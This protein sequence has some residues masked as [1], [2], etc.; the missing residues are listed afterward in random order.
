MGEGKHFGVW[1]EKRRSMFRDKFPFSTISVTIKFEA[2]PEKMKKIVFCFALACVMYA[3]CTGKKQQFLPEATPDKEISII[4]G[5]DTVTSIRIIA[6]DSLPD[7]DDV[8]SGN[9]IPEL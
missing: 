2:K 8:K 1:T 4:G 6:Q 3:G 5:C 9:A 7:K